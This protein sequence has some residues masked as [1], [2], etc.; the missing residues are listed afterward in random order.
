MGLDKNNKPE[1]RVQRRAASLLVLVLA[2]LSVPIPIISGLSIRDCRRP[3]PRPI[4][5][6]G[7]PWS[8]SPCFE[9]PVSE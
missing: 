1:Q 5:R 9:A 8:W 3:V 2:V 6:G 7:H 4:R